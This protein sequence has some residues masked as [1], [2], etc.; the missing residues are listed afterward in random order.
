DD[1]R[2]LHPRN[3]H[4]DGRGPD[5]LRFALGHTGTSNPR[6]EALAA[7]EYRG[8][9]HHFHSYSPSVNRSSILNLH[10]QR[11]HGACRRAT[12]LRR[13]I[14]CALSLNDPVRPRQERGLEREAERLGGLE[15]DDELELGRLLHGKI[16]RF[17]P[18]RILST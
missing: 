17:G 16:G 3:L 10:R 11:S 1:L 12:L 7:L 14:S 15:V 13:W 6:A 18:R 2:S 4:A 8:M 9:R 5:H